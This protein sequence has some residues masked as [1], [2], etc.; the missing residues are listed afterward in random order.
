MI[1]LHGWG[2]HI[3]DSGHDLSNVI[4]LH[5]VLMS[6][7]SSNIIRLINYNNTIAAQLA[8]WPDY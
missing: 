2:N 7:W 6:V 1:V 3:D 5:V 4:S 8:I